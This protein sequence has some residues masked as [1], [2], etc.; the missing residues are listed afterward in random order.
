M[1]DE[2]VANNASSAQR[3]HAQQNQASSEPI[4]CL[5]IVKRKGRRAIPGS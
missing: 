3:L 1:A 5:P 4:P 2:P